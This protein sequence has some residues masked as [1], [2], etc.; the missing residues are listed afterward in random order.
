MNDKD[1]RMLVQ[2]LIQ[3]LAREF[4][5]LS[6][7]LQHQFDESVLAR[8]RSQIQEVDTLEGIREFCWIGSK[9][10]TVIMLPLTRPRATV[11]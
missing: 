7:R 10:S 9:R 2:S 8:L 4:G 1:I 5:E 11:Q 6:E 3:M